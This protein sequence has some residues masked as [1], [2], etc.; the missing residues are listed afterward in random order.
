MSIQRPIWLPK[1]LPELDGL[2]GIAILLV[3]LYHCH[4]RLVGTPLYRIV[5]WGWSGVTLFFFMSG[6]LIT[7]NLLETRDKP[8]Y[9][10]HF[11][12]RR[13]LRI[14]PVY[15]LILAFVYANAPWYI[16]PS[17]WDAI[18]TAPWWAY[19]L[20]L[21]NLFPLALPPALG[22][23][24]ALAIEEQY[25]FV[26]APLVRWLRNPAMLAAPLV[27][28]LIAAPV[29]RHAHLH[30]IT[31]THTLIHLDGLALGSLL[32]LA[33]YTL[34]ISRRI[35]FGVGLVSFVAGFAS[36]FTIAG[37]TVFL[38]TA[39][40]FG[41]GGAVLTAVAS[42]AAKTPLHAVLRRGPL[43]F[44]GRVSYGLYLTHIAV[45]VYFGWFD[46]RMDSY[47]ITG[48]L[49][50]V[51]FRLATSTAVAAV[52]WYGFESRVLKLKRHF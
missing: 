49:A 4:P 18:R 34:T 41:Y 50:V 20:F 16:G 32:G 29:I 40:A 37:G 7:W 25:Y 52:L 1:Y 27:S 43:A 24:W 31:P 35:W 2:R 30:W 23:T 3:V 12:A 51:A 36:A 10:H 21:Q 39:L 17:V 38:D 5:I 26:W 13:A 14:W 11:H 47:G 19:L 46:L 15:L 45:F 42:T 28:A 22:P 6:M 44:Y 8:H 9:F 33:L 48:N